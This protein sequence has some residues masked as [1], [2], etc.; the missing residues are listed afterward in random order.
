VVPEMA[1]IKSDQK[2]NGLCAWKNVETCMPSFQSQIGRFQLTAPTC[3][4]IWH[5]VK[6]NH[7]PL[8]KRQYRIYFH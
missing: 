6:S 1:L 7:R 4:L 5:R 2:I 8:L 3:E